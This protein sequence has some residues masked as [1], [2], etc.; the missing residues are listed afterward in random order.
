ML[1]VFPT[2]NDVCCGLIIYGLYYVEVGSFYALLFK[3]SF[4][5]K[6]VLT[7]VKSFFSIYWDY[8]MVYIFQFVNMV[9]CID[10]FAYI[11][12]SLH[13]WNK[14]NLIMAYELFDVLL[15]S[16]AKILLRIFASMFIS[17]IGLKFSFSICCLCQLLVSGWWW[18]HR[19]SLEVFLPLQFF[20]SFRRVGICSL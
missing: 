11:E 8:H 10:W 13:P 15:N 2:D 4:N 16:V 12:E 9:Y 7:F 19:M 5:H 3:K 18:S 17:D 6:Q 14:S 1:S 20:E